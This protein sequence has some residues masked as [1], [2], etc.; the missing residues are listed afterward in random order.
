M[1]LATINSIATTESLHKNLDNLPF[2][3]AYINGNMDMI[4]SCFNANYLQIMACG[5]TVNDPLS[6]IVVGYLAL[7]DNA[8][9]KSYSANKSAYTQCLLAWL[10]G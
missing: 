1:H 6:K 2:Y 4:N 9:K 3:A 8:L 5:I 10:R 7:T